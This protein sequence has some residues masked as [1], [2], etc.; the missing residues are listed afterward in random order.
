MVGNLAQG[1]IVVVVRLVGSRLVGIDGLDY[2]IG[3]VVRECAQVS[4]AFWVFRNGFG[5]NVAGAGKCRLGRVEASILV[6]VCR[7]GIERAALG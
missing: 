4:H 7:G 6:D 3:G 5:H 2:D 1:L